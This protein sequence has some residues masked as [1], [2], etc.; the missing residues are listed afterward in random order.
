MKS[1]YTTTALLALS[2]AVSLP[3]YWYFE[4][5]LFF[6]RMLFPPPT[7]VLRIGDFV[8]IVMQIL[9]ISLLVS[10]RAVYFYQTDAGPEVI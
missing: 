5:G 10:F 7:D 2:L 9:W 6:E 1:N 3:I 8:A 4:F